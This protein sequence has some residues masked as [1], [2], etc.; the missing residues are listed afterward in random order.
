MTTFKTTCTKCGHESTIT[1]EAVLP[2]KSS[3]CDNC[4]QSANRVFARVD[5][6][7]LKKA[8][9]GEVDSILANTNTKIVGK[10]G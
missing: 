4:N 9:P 7:S 5:I 10:T 3:H 6:S 2:S 1:L 8:S